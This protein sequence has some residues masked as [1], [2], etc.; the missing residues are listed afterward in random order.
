MPGPETRGSRQ[1]RPPQEQSTLPFG[2]TMIIRYLLS[3][4]MRN[5]QAVLSSDEASAHPVPIAM[6]SIRSWL[7]HS[8]TEIRNPGRTKVIYD[9]D[10][11]LKKR[12]KGGYIGKPSRLS[13]LFVCCCTKSLPSQN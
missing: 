13:M 3:H 1:P 12:Q 10:R 9:C 8:Q 11:R 7:R 6:S 2:S 5:E 4:P